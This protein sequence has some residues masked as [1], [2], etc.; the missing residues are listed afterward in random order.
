MCIRDRIRA[1]F[2]TCLSGMPSRV[3]ADWD[4]VGR[5]GRQ[6]PSRGVVGDAVARRAGN[7]RRWLDLT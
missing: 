2:G 1:T 7:E 5:I 4:G 3:E 6:V